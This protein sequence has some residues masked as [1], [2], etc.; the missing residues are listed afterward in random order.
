MIAHP[1]TNREIHEEAEAAWAKRFPWLLPLATSI[2]LG[3]AVF[4][5]MPEALESV[6][7]TGWLW[8]VVG[9][10]DLSSSR[11]DLTTSVSA[12]WLGSLHSVFG[13]TPLWKELSQ[14][15]ATKSIS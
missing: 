9:L 2:F 11:M 7:G 10:S 5:T 14:Q 3:A 8:L 1:A 6:G 12:D 13:C 15:R 4:E